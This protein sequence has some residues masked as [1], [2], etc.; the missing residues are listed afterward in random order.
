MATPVQTDTGAFGPDDM[1]R[2]AEKMSDNLP[3]T[4]GIEISKASL[5]CHAHPAGAERQF[6]DTAKGHK[7]LIA[8]LRP[9][10]IERV[11]Y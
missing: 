11:A 7:A 9:W 4:I 3:R 8:C 2:T 5:D 10:S 1:H 6:A